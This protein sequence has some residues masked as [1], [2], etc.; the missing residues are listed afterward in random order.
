MSQSPPFSRPGLP[1]SALPLARAVHTASTARA[2]CLAATMV[3]ST[4]AA[5]G[6]AS[7]G[8]PDDAGAPLVADQRQQAA[9][10]ATDATAPL[11]QAINQAVANGESLARVQN[12]FGAEPVRLPGGSAVTAV[13]VEYGGTIVADVTL[14]EPVPAPAPAASAPAPAAGG[15]A[16]PP[17][18]P[19]R[20]QLIWVAYPAAA[21][22]V[23][24][25]CFGSYASVAKDTGGACL[26]P[27]DAARGMTWGTASGPAAA[28]LTPY[29]ATYDISMLE[30]NVTTPPTS[31]RSGAPNACNPYDGDWHVLRKL[32]LLCVQKAGLP[33]PTGWRPVPQVRGFVG[34][35]VAVTPPV[36]G[37]QLLGAAAGNSLCTQELGTGWTM[38][39]FHDAGGWGFYGIGRTPTDTRMWTRI[40]DTSANPWCATFTGL[41]CQE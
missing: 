40:R 28:G 6:G 37:V 34:G 18:T 22:V 29:D 3:A 1:P 19:G 33:P 10:L 8:I 11:R 7:V 30:C 36:Y 41:P 26:Y 35:A 2:R 20:G 12:N 27:G 24:W 38:A 13:R 21:G 14:A 17:D 39:A 23:R 9:A 25:Y 5:C 15:V 16:Q 4:L 31:G 32:P